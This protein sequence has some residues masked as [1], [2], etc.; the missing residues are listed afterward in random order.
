[1]SDAWDPSLYDPT[2]QVPDGRVL[3]AAGGRTGTLELENG[4]KL[5]F[6]WKAQQQITDSAPPRI[7]SY[8]VDTGGQHTL[9]FQ[10]GGAVM[11]AN[12]PTID[13]QAPF[14]DETDEPW[15]TLSS[16]GY[17]SSDQ[18]S[19]VL[20]GHATLG[21]IELYGA[22][23]GFDSLAIDDITNRIGA[24]TIDSSSSLTLRSGGTLTVQPDANQNLA[25]TTTGTG[26]IALTAGDDITLSPGGDL[27]LYSTGGPI[28][29][30]GGLNQDVN[31]TA[32]GTGQV[33]I[34]YAGT[35]LI[36]DGA[37]VVTIGS[38]TA[39]INIGGYP[40]S[41]AWSAYTPTLGG[42]G[43]ALGNGSLN[44]FYM[45]LG[46]L[47]ILRVRFTLGSTSTV[48]STLTFALPSGMTAV[49]QTDQFQMFPGM[50]RDTGTV[51]YLGMFRATSGSTAVTA[52][53]LGASGTYTSVNA[54]SS[55][56]PHTWA[57][58]DVVSFVGIIEV[59]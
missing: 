32:T 7:Q 50:L 56:V 24:M 14:P 22:I 12:A 43:T 9:G 26:D 39:I 58:T 48:G 29:M 16:G 21:T 38:T 28:T 2:T 35:T 45:R 44:G 15:M 11:D 49:T 8:E 54:V 5:R 55:T 27:N 42:T 3:I 23:T 59:A 30:T 25:L 6:P 18:S 19:I 31:I 40:F 33:E 13:M 10:L 1:M 47:L 4:A 51:E 37:G 41:G 36:G 53:A 34:G 57:N 17:P 52:Y 20:R 46:K